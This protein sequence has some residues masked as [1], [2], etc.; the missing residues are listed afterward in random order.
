MQED[1]ENYVIL[2]WQAPEYRH[3]SKS[4]AWFITLFIVLSAFVLYLILRKDYF[5]AMS[6]V[7]V[8]FFFT[9]FALREPE[10]IDIAITD[11]GIYIGEHLIRYRLIRYFWIDTDNQVLHIETSAYVNHLHAIE[12]GDQDPY[13]VQNVLIEI[14]PEHPEPKETIPQRI[15]NLLKF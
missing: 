8:S 7:I 15:A 2:N 12:L 11:E 4:M 3:H 10:H 1:N 5:G 14:L 13:E 9:V 6:V